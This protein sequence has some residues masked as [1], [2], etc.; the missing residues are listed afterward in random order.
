M[1][2]TLKRFFVA[3]LAIVTLST[4]LLVSGGAQSRP[5]SAYEQERTNVSPADQDAS[6]QG[7]GT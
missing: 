4:A 2:G 3:S 7:Q 1:N 6:I 5:Y